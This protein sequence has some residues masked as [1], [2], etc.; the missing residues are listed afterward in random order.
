MGMIKFCSIRLD[1]SSF[2]LQVPLDGWQYVMEQH[3]R[4]LTLG[5]QGTWFACP[6]P[7]ANSGPSLIV[8]SE[9]YKI[10]NE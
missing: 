8:E 7:S 10:S 3:E 5:T 1:Q 6:P 2:R 4:E 9:D